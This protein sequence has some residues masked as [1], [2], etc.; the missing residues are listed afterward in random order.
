MKLLYPTFSVAV[1]AVHEKVAFITGQRPDMQA[2]L[3][4]IPDFATLVMKG[5]LDNTVRLEVAGVK[6][7]CKKMKEEINVVDEGAMGGAVGIERTLTDRLDGLEAIAKLSNSTP[8][9]DNRS[10]W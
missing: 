3:K 1:R 9:R 6:S 5:I 8:K 2:E 4:V 10:K 7:A